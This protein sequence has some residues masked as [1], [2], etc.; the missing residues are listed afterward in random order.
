[1]SKDTYTDTKRDQKMKTCQNVNDGYLK[2]KVI[3]N[4]YPFFV[5]FYFPTVL[6]WEYSVYALYLQN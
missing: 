2:K 6:Q 1:M 5:L 3:I 4:L